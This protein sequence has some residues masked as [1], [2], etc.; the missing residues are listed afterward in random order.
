MSGI[1]GIPRNLPGLIE[2]PGGR[3]VS[4]GPEEPTKQAEFTEML[5]NLLND[6]NGLHQE[7]GQMQQA[8]LSGDP[9]ELH[10]IMIKA[11][12][13]G[14]ATDLLLEIRDKLVTAYNEIMRM[15]L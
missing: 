3:K 8:F 14:I 9:V 6:V 15:P 7:S 11:E 2:P 5:G 1:N 12:Q 13:A 4:L 10:Q